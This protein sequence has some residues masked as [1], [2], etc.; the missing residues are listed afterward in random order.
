M[1]TALIH[2]RDRSGTWQ[3]VRALVDSASQI[4]AITVSCAERLGLRPR[5]WTMPV[6][7]LSGTPVLDIKGVVDCDVRP[8]FAHDPTL[9]VRT[10]VLP[11]I[12]G[13]MPRNSFSSD[14]KNRCSSLA[15]ADPHFYVSAQV[16]LLLGADVF[17]SILD[18]RQVKIDAS[19]PTAFSSFFGWILIGPLPLITVYPSHTT[20]VSLTV[21]IESLM[22]QFWSNEEP[23]AAPSSFTDDGWCKNQ[24][25]VEHRRLPSGR[26]MVPLLTRLPLSQISF[27]GSRDVAVRRFESL[28]RKLQSNSDLRIAY[29]T[30]MAEYLSLGHMSV[31]TEP[32][33]YMIPHHAVY[34]EVDGGIKIRVVFDAS[35][36]D[37]DGVSLNSCLHQGP[38]LQQD[39]AD[40]LTRFRVHRFAFTTDICKM[41]RQ[42][43]MA[44]EYR[45][46]QHILWRASPHDQ[47]VEYQLNT[48]TYGLNCAPFL[49]L[50]VLAAIA[51]NDC[52]RP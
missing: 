1:G 50:R 21:S 35:A 46:L 34:S 10:W 3:T 6:S 27:S 48:V 12:I 43:L 39:I 13:D 36:V 16:D 49:A 37:R 40:I 25:R 23:D 7:G 28:E 15:L 47:L 9:S 44:P 17:S 18:G 51:D 42:V 45:P 8:R 22:S 41:Y 31:A 19:L 20:S 29:C 33:R 4:S 24:F 38:K 32:G 5:H 11:S 2:A 14:I 30:F 26:F 52:A